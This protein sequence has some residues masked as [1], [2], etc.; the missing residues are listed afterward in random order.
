M[1]THISL[2]MPIRVNSLSV[3]SLS[4][5][6][7]VAYTKSGEALFD[8]SWTQP[9]PFEEQPAFMDFGVR[10]FT[11]LLSI[12]SVEDCETYSSAH[13]ACCLLSWKWKS[14]SQ[15][16]LM[17]KADYFSR[18][19]KD[20]NELKCLMEM[21]RILA[22]Y[23]SHDFSHEREAKL[24][25]S[26]IKQRE[27]IPG[28][29]FDG[30]DWVPCHNYL[31]SMDIASEDYFLAHLSIESLHSRIQGHIDAYLE[32]VDTKFSFSKSLITLECHS[33]LEAMY[34]FYCISDIN[35]DEYRQCNNKRCGVYFK[36]DK[37]HRQKF[38][39]KHM[40]ARRTKRINAKEK[41]KREDALLENE[42]GNF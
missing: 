6:P 13:P 41:E 18:V 12:S 38:C 25:S 40:K 14:S 30:P 16:K 34:I 2:V 1:D 42:L 39:E 31:L 33:A 17:T 4:A 35:K 5:F 29:I 36:V 7:V 15:A 11:D 10:E 32:D 24:M 37:T 8:F 27:S 9:E 26:L 23:R 22:E 20:I 3:D 28:V 19:Y 21:S